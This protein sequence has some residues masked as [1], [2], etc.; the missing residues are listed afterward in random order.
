M[1]N[2]I[3]EPITLA[4]RKLPPF[5]FVLLTRLI[6]EFL[7]LE[8]GDTEPVYILPPPAALNPPDCLKL[9]L[10]LKSTGFMARVYALP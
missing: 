4:S 2:E 5:C 10:G 3:G 1:I 8:V 6:G 9:P 7:G